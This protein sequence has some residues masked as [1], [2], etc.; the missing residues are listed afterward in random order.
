MK[1]I[2][3]S[4]RNM[5]ENQK[6]LKKIIFRVLIVLIFVI[7]V[8]LRVYGIDKMPNALNVDEALPS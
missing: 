4:V 5:L 3:G 8:F 6:E 1:K 2:Y 7:G